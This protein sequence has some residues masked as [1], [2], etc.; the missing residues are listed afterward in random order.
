MF[1]NASFY[2]LCILCIFLSSCVSKAKYLELETSL[3]N[4]ETQL[5]DSN[6]ALWDL[7]DRHDELYSENAQ[8]SG[9]VGD[10]THNLDQARSDIRE[11]EDTIGEL[12]DNLRQA[13]S[14]INQQASRGNSARRTA[15]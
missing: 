14:V 10:I 7:Q 1:K 8:L 4:T 5:K 3:R 2:T 6:E 12:T 15:D 13:A 9:T 11:K